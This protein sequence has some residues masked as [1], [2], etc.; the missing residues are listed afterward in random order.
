MT[1]VLILRTG[2][3]GGWYGDDKS[4]VDYIVVLCISAYLSNI[5][6]HLVEHTYTHIVPL[7]TWREARKDCGL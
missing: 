7:E 6:H 3:F 1:I 2:D 4:R 5:F